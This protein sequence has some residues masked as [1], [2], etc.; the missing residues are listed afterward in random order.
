[1]T[2]PQTPHTPAGWYPDPAGTGG[3][4]WW[5]GIDWTDDVQTSYV[6]AH[7]R[8]PIPAAAAGTPAYNI[9]TWVI[10]ALLALS[11]V[12]AFFV[13]IESQLL[14][15]VNEGIT[16]VPAPVDWGMILLQLSSWVIYGAS[17]VFAYL[18]WREIKRSGVQQPF[19][20]AWS[21]LS[22]LVYLIGRAVIMK[23]R[24]G[25]GMATMWIAIAY[26]VFIVIYTIVVIGMTVS[27]IMNMPDLMY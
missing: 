6:E 9:H 8:Q 19:H 1:M 11:A 15:G 13:N 23:R 4:R 24:V 3:K 22:I 2:T 12:S 27:I 10:L 5:N 26:L 25:A 18:D 20:W 17:V 16:G 7:L 14:A 21:F